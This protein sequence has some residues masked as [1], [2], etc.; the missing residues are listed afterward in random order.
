MEEPPTHKLINQK[1][2]SRLLRLLVA[3]KELIQAA[4]K[5]HLELLEQQRRLYLKARAASLTQVRRTRVY[6]VAPLPHLR[7]HLC[8]RP[9]LPKPAS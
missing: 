9:A 7:W 8:W 1:R 4:G 6:R 2:T 5:V 3:E